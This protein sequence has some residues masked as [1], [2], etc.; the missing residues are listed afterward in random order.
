MSA[1]VGEGFSPLSGERPDGSMDYIVISGISC[2]L[3]ESENMEEFKNHLMKGDNMVTKNRRW[4][5]GDV[6][7]LNKYSVIG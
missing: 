3:P 4:E 2:R 5:P 6:L 1:C 7:L